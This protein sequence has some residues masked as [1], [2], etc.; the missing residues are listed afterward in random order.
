MNLF[1][2]TLTQMTILLFFLLCGYLMQKTKYLPENSPAVLSKLE[3]MVFMPA[4]VLDTLSTKFT[5]ESLSSSWRIFAAGMIFTAVSVPVGL[6]LSGICS[7]DSYI[8]KLFA[9]GLCFPNTGFVGNA[10]FK[11][12][13]PDQ[14][15]LYLI[16]TLPQTLLVYAWGVPFLLAPT[17]IQTAVPRKR[18]MIHSFLNPTF[19]A[20]FV[21]IVIGLSGLRL[22]YV[23]STI[24][25]T[26]NNCMSPVAML[27]TGITVAHYKLAEL[28]RDRGV[29]IVSFLRLI[30][31]PALVGILC[32]VLQLPELYTTC[33]IGTAALPLGLNT[34]VIPAAYGREQPTGTSMALISHGVSV[35]TIPILFAIFI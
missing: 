6:L 13:F 15:F 24:I 14:F 18:Q 23:L 11:A 4:L 32:V 2:P 7:R 12:L 20:T 19:L 1:A 33:L 31:L 26:A 9:Y 21:G 27:L 17:N 10:I 5:V 35:I 28:L 22:P 25:T 29:Y 30:A 34:V 8:R 16:F 3:N